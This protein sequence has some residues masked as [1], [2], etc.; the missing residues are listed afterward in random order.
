M[1]SN[2]TPVEVRNLIEEYAALSAEADTTRQGLRC[3]VALAD[4]NKALAKLPLKLWEVVLVHGLL[5]IP[6]QEAAEE[7]HMKQQTL[8]KRYRQGLEDVH[9]FINGGDDA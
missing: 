1:R 6:Q 5:G 9:W 4:L 8:G 7:L 3:L 2:Y